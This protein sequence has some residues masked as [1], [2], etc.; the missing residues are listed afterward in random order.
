MIMIIHDS[1]LL[2]LAVVLTSVL[3]IAAVFYY[4]YCKKGIMI[5]FV[6]VVIFHCHC[7][8][9][10]FICCCHFCVVCSYEPRPRGRFEA[11]Y[12]ITSCSVDNDAL[13]ELKKKIISA[14]ARVK[15]VPLLPVFPLLKPIS[16]LPQG[17]YAQ[18]GK[19]VCRV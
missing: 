18:A 17:K 1:V 11:G 6:V 9:Y 14:F 2:P 7:V 13:S 5:L 19:S 15:M 4:R 3:L 12:V 8:I 16:F 10:T